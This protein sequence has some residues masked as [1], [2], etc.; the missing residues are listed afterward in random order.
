MRRQ[1]IFI[2]LLN[3]LSVGVSATEVDFSK[4]YVIPQKE[5]INEIQI[6]GI[7]VNGDNYSITNSI[8]LGFNPDD[9]SFHLLSAGQQILDA[10]LFAQRLRGT[11]WTGTYSA[12]QNQYVTELYF[13]SIQNGF[14]GGEMIHKTADAEPATF[15]RAKVV[16]DI[17]TQYL[18]TEHDESVWK[19]A[20]DVVDEE[21]FATITA[22]R[23][24]IRMKRI[25]A[26][27]AHHT[28]SGW[29]TNNEYRL[30]L[31]DNRLTGSVGTPSDKFSN[32]DAMT[33]NGII[34]LWEK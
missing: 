23:S 10:E 20:E 9:A 18:V 34:E 13:Q 27:E 24:L 28:G 29:G 26:L 4:A 3:L 17:I 31:E 1:I 12:P 15:L 19:N 7:M 8:L 5:A 6:G 25:R 14:V 30:T 2:S 22:T 16:G 32:N 33:G 21:Q 11:T